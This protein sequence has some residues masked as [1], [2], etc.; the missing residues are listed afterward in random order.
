MAIAPPVERPDQAVSPRVR[1]VRRRGYD[2]LS[3]R[4]LNKDTA[5]TEAERVALGLRGLLPARVTTIDEQVALELE[6]VRRKPD[7]LER[8]I[9]LAALQDRNETLFFRLLAENLEE[10]LPV[11]YTP[12]VGRA[13]QEFSHILRRARGVWI[14][15]ADV[16]RIPELLRNAADDV[17]LIV[18][19]DNERI[20]GLGDQGAGG[21]P[22]PVGKLALYTGGAG[23]HP[24]WTLPVSLDVGT[25]RDDLL[26]DPLYLGYRGRR[27]RGEAYDAVVEAFAEA[28]RE[29]F[30]RA[31][32]QWEDFKQHN[33]LRILE[34]YRHR[35]PSFNDDVQ[36]TAAV[37]LAGL[38]AARRDDGGLERDRFLFLGAGAAAVGTAGLLAQ[39]LASRGLSADL[40]RRSI[41]M[42][43]SH[44]LV[45]V[46]R[47]DLDADK[48]LFAVDAATIAGWDLDRGALDRPATVA[49]AA[50]ATVL[51]GTTGCA[52][53]F[54]EPL[55]RAIAANHP[56]PIVLPLS[57]P[58][59]RSE[60]T[61]DQVL[62]WSRGQAIVATGSPFGPPPGRAF[63]AVG[64]ANN[65]FVFPGVGLGAIVAE[66]REITDELF[67]VAA[68]TLAANVTPARLAAGAIYPAVGDLRAISRSIAV[69]VVRTARDSGYG[70]N[71]RDAEI[72]PAVD[73]AIWWPEYVP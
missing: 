63:R 50:G 44:G 71:F 61:P 19:T 67:L 16:D 55:V 32:L 40:I 9:G 34:R 20:L 12:T 15:P 47:T 6:H 36:G 18:V 8:Y 3:D 66:T 49:A 38:L 10:F 27:L 58:S 4:V 26:A 46:G 13:C 14:T 11:V 17:R 65:V 52:N 22:I 57:N 42:V 25:D 24:A 29:V 45:H 41:V 53:A 37:V 7:D 43:D 70:R 69:A 35:L 64:Q 54:D 39:E 59:S 48:R 28:V 51:I 68:R 72:E 23:I 2:I 1:R 5:F 60:A 33:A 62:E 30:P 56:R 21:M 31:V 73:D